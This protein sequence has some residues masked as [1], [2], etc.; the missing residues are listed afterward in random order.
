MS[1]LEPLS[2]LD[3]FLAAAL[4]DS[5]SGM[6]LD[7]LGASVFPIET[8]AAFNTQ[9]V[10]AKLKAMDAVGLGDDNIE[11]ILISL[12]TQYHLIRPLDSNREVFIYI[13]LD[14]KRANLAIARIELRKLESTI[15][16]L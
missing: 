13:A 12:G 1:K 8:A 15:K 3:G 7:S 2:N 14:R 10:Q 5:G 16:K 6:L 4:V 11:D 9:V